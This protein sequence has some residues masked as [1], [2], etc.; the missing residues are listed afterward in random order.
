M[1]MK[2]Y[3]LKSVAAAAFVGA[4][5]FAT[6]FAQQATSPA[7]TLPLFC[8]NVTRP[9]PYS[10]ISENVKHLQSLLRNQYGYQV[11]STGYFGSV[12]ARYINA[13]QRTLG[14]RYPFGSLGPITLGKLRSIWCSGNTGV[15][16]PPSTGDILISLN[17]ISSYGNNVTVGWNVQNA[18]SCTLNGASVNPVSGTQ[19]AT[20]YSETNYTMACLDQN[21]KTAQQT[22]AVRPNGTTTIGAQPA[23]SIYASPSTF[24]VGQTVMIVWS[25]TNATS[26]TLNGQTVATSGVQNIVVGS[27]TSYTIN[28]S[29][30]GYTASQTLSAGG[31]ITNCPAGTTLLNGTCTQTNICTAEAR[32]CPNGQLMP[33]DPNC[34]WRSDLCSN[35]ISAPIINSFV[36]NNNTYLSWNTTNASS[37]TLSGQGISNQTVSTSGNQYLPSYQNGSVVGPFTLTCTSSSGQ[38]VSSTVSANTTLNQQDQVTLNSSTYKTGNT[39]N[40]SWSAPSSYSSQVQGVLLE[41]VKDGSV[42]GTITRI[43]GSS[44]SNGSY[45][46]VIPK[47]ITDT[48]NDAIQCTVVNSENLCGNVLSSG[49]YTVRATYFTPSNACFGFCPQ[50]AGQQVLGS[51][52]SQTFN[53]TTLNTTT[54]SSFSATNNSGTVF[55]SWSSVGSSSCSL[56]RYTSLGPIDDSYSQINKVLVNSTLPASGIYT[57]QY[58]GTDGNWLA[59]GRMQL[60]LECGSN[61]SNTSVVGI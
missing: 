59:L 27:Q 44:A 54:V 58:I 23:V 6:T 52:G 35:T 10:E 49:N 7:N 9:I 40:I 2:K 26:C 47:S 43:Y 4:A 16:T 42:V 1:C 48:R 36:N 28:C 15:V 20:I 53:L 45:S 24:A 50:V 41:L 19:S 5:M 21:G 11:A 32:L 8:N 51:V 61:V 13:V 56:Y 3:I 29:G 34:T 60:S 46:F 39:M 30:N 14:I 22:I 17:P 38:S 37:C 55:L 25:S 31:V 12:T 18:T 57:M 33:R